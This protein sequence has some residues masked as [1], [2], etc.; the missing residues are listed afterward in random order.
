MQLLKDYT[1]YSAEDFL[2]DSQ[3]VSS[4]INPTEESREFW[5]KQLNHINVKEYER[6]VSFIQS[7]L[8]RKRRLPP[9]EE[10]QLLERI[11]N[12]NR[13]SAPANKRRRLFAKLS[14]ATACIAVFL[15]IPFTYLYKKSTS[16]TD[17]AEI[18]RIMR[19]GE[20]PG[21]IRLILPDEKPIEAGRQESVIEHRPDGEIKVNSGSRIVYPL[22][23]DS[24]KREIYV[25]G[26]I[27][28]DVE[29]DKSRPFH[30]KTSKMDILVHGTSF[31]VLAYEN[32]STQAV[33]LVSGLISV[34]TEREKER[35]LDPNLMLSYA[36]GRSLVRKV[37]VDDYTSWRNGLY[38][39]YDEDL[40]I[41]LDR[42]SR[43]YGKTI[44]YD[45]R[46]APL[47]FS[48]KLDMKENI[49][50]IFDGL[51]HAAPIRIEKEN[52]TYLVSSGEKE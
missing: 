11:M 47:K 45:A 17:I 37:D 3:F 44:K 40:S 24:N 8:K 46:V 31:N 18:A 48:G 19:P 38:N 51:R 43:Y 35:R 30:V 4:V 32:D 21:G 36:G 26:E 13:H 27:Y 52:D 12:S 1:D 22:A 23:Y 41:I 50:D 33:T 9:E 10:N 20:S 49:D 42:L 28:I 25:D 15:A 6:A 39:S 7:L 16:G 14:V 29:P 2:N 5:R 34:K